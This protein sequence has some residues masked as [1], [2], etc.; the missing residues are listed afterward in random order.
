[1]PNGRNSKVTLI[2]KAC[3]TPFHPWYRWSKTAQFC[4]RAC[5]PGRPRTES[6][7]RLCD[8]CGVL[9]RPQRRKGRQV[10]QGQKF[11]S[12]GCHRASGR[13][14]YVDKD[15]YARIYRPDHPRASKNWILE[16]RVVVEEQLGRLLDAHETVHH[17]NG[18]KDDNRP[19]NLQVR[20][21]RHG[22]GA[23]AVCGDC[24]SRNIT[25]ESL[26]L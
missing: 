11:C 20:S 13:M 23:V 24:G 9:Y 7:D 1:M 18:I 6:K 2:C 5:N 15:G 16:H 10:G 17:I 12:R 19:E 3:G 26:P 14:R 4:S 22:Q 8:H 25:F 21:G